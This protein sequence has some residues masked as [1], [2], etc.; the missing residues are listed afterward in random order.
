MIKRVLASKYAIAFKHSVKQE[1]VSVSFET[2]ISILE[3]IVNE[4]DVFEFF[5]SPIV[6]IKR[7]TES[8]DK[9]I[10]RIKVSE[11]INN[12]LQLII[13]KNRLE[14][15]PELIAELKNE[16]NV[17]LNQVEVKCYTAVDLTDEIKEKIKKTIKTFTDKKI[18]VDFIEDPELLGGFRF[19][20]D[21]KLYDGSLK[22]ALYKI[23]S[24]SDSL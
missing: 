17:V 22:N 2:L 8:L 20:M 24:Y 19:L 11:K 9:I 14:I 12:F 7:K 23:K 18:V 4:S 1:E 15:L 16:L 3:N 10:E 21:N 6:D 5:K 13:S